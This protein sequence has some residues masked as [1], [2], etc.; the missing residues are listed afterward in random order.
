MEARE[1]GSAV[2]LIALVVVLIGCVVVGLGRLGAA[3]AARAAARTAADA[4]ALAG[5]ADGRAAAEALAEANGAEL[6]GYEGI[7]LDTGSPCG[8]ARRRRLAGRGGWA[9]AVPVRAHRRWVG[10]RGRAGWRRP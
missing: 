7:G 8:S 5:A 4:A 2:P 1:R 10:E 9:A 3:G 6:V